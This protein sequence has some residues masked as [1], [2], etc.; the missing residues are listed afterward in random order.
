L[1]H[2]SLVV[3]GFSL[4]LGSLEGGHLASVLVLCSI[5]GAQGIFNYSV[6]LPSMRYCRVPTLLCVIVDD[7]YL[8]VYLPPGSTIIRNLRYTA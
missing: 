1:E 2:Y 6:P 8:R 7:Q 3:P 5:A 4:F